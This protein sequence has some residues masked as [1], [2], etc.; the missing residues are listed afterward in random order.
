MPLAPTFCLR[1]LDMMRSWRELAAAD[2]AVTSRFVDTSVVKSHKV[3]L[4]E[5]NPLNELLVTQL[6]DSYLKT[7]Q[8]FAIREVNYLPKQNFTNLGIFALDDL[9]GNDLLDVVGFLAELPCNANLPETD[10]SIVY[11]EQDKSDNLML[12]PLSFVNSS[13]LPNCVYTRNRDTMGLKTIRDVK[14]GEELTVKYSHSYFGTN[15]CDCLC[16]H[17]ELHGQG[18]LV[19]KSRTRSCAKKVGEKGILLD[20]NKITRERHPVPIDNRKA[21]LTLFSY[22]VCS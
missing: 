14:K 12:G 10:V 11:S 20:L 19:L 22:Y 4:K 7:F 16:P 1:F 21:L 17:K 5:H 8:N 3:P 6:S 9:K 2:A 13:C 18:V 15:N